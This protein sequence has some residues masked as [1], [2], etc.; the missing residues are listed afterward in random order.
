M[1][2]FVVL[3]ETN[4]VLVN[5]S[6]TLNASI[7]PLFNALQVSW[8]MNGTEQ[9]SNTALT[10]HDNIE[11]TNSFTSTLTVDITGYDKTGNY[12]CIASLAGSV[13][14]MSDCLIVTVSGTVHK[15]CMII[16][17]SNYVHF[18]EISISENYSNLQVGSTTS[19]TCTV[20]GIPPEAVLW[21]DT[22]TGA[23]AV[24]P[25]VLMLSSVD[26]TLSGIEFACSVNSPKLYRPGERKITVTVKG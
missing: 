11:Y 22:W 21:S 7:G 25:G 1:K 9:Q 13:Q 19:I 4:F 5:C 10:P 26:S 8:L 6:I 17:K 20:L 23:S 12:C 14:S 15:F 2:N 16:K 3:L 18:L 24:S